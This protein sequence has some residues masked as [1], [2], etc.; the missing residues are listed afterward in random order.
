[1]AARFLQILG[2]P[3][4]ER[5]ATSS[6][7]ASHLPLSGEGRGKR[8]ATPVCGLVRNDTLYS[9]VPQERY[10]AVPNGMTITD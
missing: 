4:K 3:G 8:I 10:R 6:G 5:G 1:M 7:S 2:A 9:G